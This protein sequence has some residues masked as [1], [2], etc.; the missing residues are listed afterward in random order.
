MSSG[1]SP[2]NTRSAS[3]P[4][5]SAA[6]S[7]ESKRPPKVPAVVL[8]PRIDRRVA[9]RR[10][11]LRHGCRPKPPAVLLDAGRDQKDNRVRWQRCQPSRSAPV[12]E[13]SRTK[14][15]STPRGGA[16]TCERNSSSYQASSGYAPHTMNAWRVSGCTRSAKSS[17]SFMA[18]RY[19][20]PVDLRTGRLTSRPTNTIGGR[21]G[22]RACSRPARAA[23]SA[24][25]A[26]SRSIVRPPYLRTR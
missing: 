4:V 9:R 20:W 15:N 12:A 2:R 10:Q 1:R 3:C 17:D 7:A 8:I 23:S 22:S 13:D 19:V 16:G 14:V 26:I 24:P 21:D 6:R 25:F 18:Y 5:F 11:A